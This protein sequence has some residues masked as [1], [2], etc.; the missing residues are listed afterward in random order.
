M[1]ILALLAALVPAAAASDAYSA[2][3]WPKGEVR[4]L[5]VETD[6]GSITLRQTKDGPTTADLS[7]A[8]KPG[9][10]CRV[11]EE[12]KGGTLRLT[13]RA[14]RGP[15]GLQRPCSAGWTVT[16]SAASVQV[17]SGSGDVVF[18]TEARKVDA[19]TGSGAITVGAT[20]PAAE[21]VLRSGSGSI[22][23][24]TPAKSIDAATGSG[25]IRLGGLAGLVKAKSG[26]GAVALE[27][28]AAPAKGAI[29][30]DTGSGSLNASFP[31]GTRLKTTLRTASGIVHNDWDGS[32]GPLTLT[33]KSGSGNATV[34][35][36][37]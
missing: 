13:V 32:D 1:V 25:D 28:S 15:L 4:A 21:L 30:V 16:A 34:T 36:K 27:W 19:R 14:A 5:V 17:R 9:D 6:G 26:G 24:D 3:S 35:R 18:D 10:D 11:S 31:S 20:S 8:A 33:F 2:K 22:G 29:S 7:P 23:G 12:L 37:P